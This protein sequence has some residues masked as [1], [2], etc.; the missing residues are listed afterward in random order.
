MSFPPATTADSSLV[1]T[2]L[3]EHLGVVSKLR[4]Q[5]KFIDEL[6]Q[7]ILDCLDHGG[8]ILLFGNGGSAADAQH[9]AA[10]FVVRYRRNR[11][12]LPAIALTTDTSILTAAG[13]DFGF[14]TVFARQIESLANPEDL[15]I[16][17]ST[18]GASANIVRALEAAKQKGSTV[19]VFTGEKANPCSALADLTFHAPSS[20][21]ARVQECHMLVGHIVCEIVEGAYLTRAESP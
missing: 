21:T 10:E 7:R 18:S 17:F 4:A 14:E 5:A 13:N 11:K 16:G 20:V 15:I 9:I 3:D 12:S 2:H 19:V 8:K 6:A 1:L